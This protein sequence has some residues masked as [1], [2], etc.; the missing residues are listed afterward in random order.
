MVAA[1][2][3]DP[4]SSTRRPPCS[5]FGE[6]RLCSP[7]PWRHPLQ[8]SLY[9]DAPPCLDAW[10]S[11]LGVGASSSHGT[12][13]SSPAP[14]LPSSLPW[15]SS[16]PAWTPPLAVPCALLCTAPR[17]CS[18]SSSPSLHGR[19]SELQPLLQLPMAYCSRRLGASPPWLATRCPPCLR[20]AAQCPV[21]ACYV[22]DEMRSKPHVV[23]FLQQP[24]RL[25]A[26]RARCFI[27]RSEQHAVDTRRLFA[28]FAQPRR[29]RH[30]PR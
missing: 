9:L 22:L 14:S 5:F 10:P 8:L 13:P 23:D 20:A 27:K 1:E 21:G 29:R 12:L 2:L 16:I 7:S 11:S 25:R 6:R 17:N 19:R 28:V 26:L 30:S 24:R 4:I 3:P 15:P 18:S